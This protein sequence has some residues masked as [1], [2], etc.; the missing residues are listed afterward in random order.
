MEN[1]IKHS[2]DI[3][4]VVRARRLPTSSKK[5]VD[6]IRRHNV[7]IFMHDCEKDYILQDGRILHAKNNDIVFFPTDSEYTVIT[8]KHGETY[9]LNFD[10]RS[11]VALSPFLFHP[12]TLTLFLNLLKMRARLGRRNIQGMK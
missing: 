3:S 9:S 10:L 11:E 5:S 12:K 1:F 4:Q 6:M 8:Q 7:F 2:F